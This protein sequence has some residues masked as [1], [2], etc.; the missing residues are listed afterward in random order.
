[1]AARRSVARRSNSPSSS[2][3]STRSGVRPCATRTSSSTEMWNLGFTPP[4][5]IH[6]RVLTRVPDALRRRTRTDWSDANK[7]GQEVDC[8]LEGPT[9]DREGNLY[10]VDIPFGLIFRI[11]PSLEWTLVTQYDGWPNG[12]ALHRDGALWIADYR[13]GL[14]RLDGAALRR[15]GV[16]PTPVL[17]H[18]NSE[19]FRGLNDLTFDARGRLYFTDQG[20][21]GLHDPTGRVYR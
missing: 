16:A 5:V 12:L 2:G 14:L 8:F 9:F 20:Q 3:R 6:A 18:R 17:G 10:V 1:M 4:F 13:R 21:T 11:A 19:S 7:P 15:G